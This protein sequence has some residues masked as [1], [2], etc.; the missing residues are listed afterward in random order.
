MRSYC[1]KNPAHGKI[2]H[3]FSVLADQAGISRASF[4]AIKQLLLSQ[5][6]KAQ[7]LT[8]ASY[9]DQTTKRNYWQSYQGRLGQLEK[10]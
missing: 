2:M 3:Q 7:E 4:E 1:Q 9:L 5:S 6:D 8:L 10:T